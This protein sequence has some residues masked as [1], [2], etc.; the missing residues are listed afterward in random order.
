MIRDNFLNEDKKDIDQRL[1]RFIMCG[2]N[3][4]QEQTE[5]VN[6]W[7]KF[8]KRW[9]ECL[10]NMS[11]NIKQRERIFPEGEL[12]CKNTLV[13]V[14]WLMNQ[15]MEYLHG[16]YPNKYPPIKFNPITK[17]QFNSLLKER[18][19][20]N[21]VNKRGHI[22]LDHWN[23]IKEGIKNDPH[24][25]IV[26]LCFEFGLRCSEALALSISNMFIDNLHIK[27]QVWKINYDNGTRVMKPTKTGDPRRIPY[28][29]SQGKLTP[30]Q[31][32]SIVDGV[33]VISPNQLTKKWRAKMNE[34]GLDYDIHDCRH[35]FCR[36]AV[37][38]FPLKTAMEYT[39]HKSVET[40]NGY[41][42][43]KTEYSTERFSRED[44][45]LAG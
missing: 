30:Q 19:R 42:Q 43:S 38:T 22:K 21:L 7:K 37:N 13:R 40:I 15:F 16:E 34:L 35:S 44:L 10:I 5:K 20:R 11:S 31:I 4:F 29:A 17:A 28:N 27:E 23:I 3:W 33:P 24:L 39:G 14:V 25:K 41:L 26:Q 36:Y 45:G 6:E 18:K 1:S 12:R 2:L 32:A 9:G 8:E